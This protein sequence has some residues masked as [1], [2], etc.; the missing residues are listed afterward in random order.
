MAAEAALAGIDLTFISVVVVGEI[1]LGESGVEVAVVLFHE[2]L[3][4]NVA[5]IHGAFGIVGV[6]AGGVVADKGGVGSEVGGDEVAVGLLAERGVV[7]AEF[8]IGNFA[9]LSVAYKP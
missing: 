7:E 4:A 9:G 1:G 6:E 8:E 5:G 3:G 2:L